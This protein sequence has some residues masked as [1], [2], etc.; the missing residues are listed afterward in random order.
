MLLVGDAACAKAR[1]V[2]MSLCSSLHVK[3][4]SLFHILLIYFRERERAR[5]RG[6]AEGE[7]EADFALSRELDPRTSG[8]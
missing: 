5:A 7:G 4:L 1:G 6:G 3:Q 2:R 8:S